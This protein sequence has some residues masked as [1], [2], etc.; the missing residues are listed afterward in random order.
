MEDACNE[1]RVIIDFEQQ[2]I[3]H[4][5]SFPI[6]K[7][8]NGDGVGCS[9]GGRRAY[10]SLSFEPLDC[11]V[12]GFDTEG[13]GQRACNYSSCEPRVHNSKIVRV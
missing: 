9:V 7:P 6:F 8:D 10:I 4:E 2:D 11:G 3:A 12:S 13:A 1:G 5:E